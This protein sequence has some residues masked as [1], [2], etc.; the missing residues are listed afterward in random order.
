M[1]DA[2]A[3]PAQELPVSWA[4]ESAV[5]QCVSSAIVLL[6]PLALE[7]RFG[8][9]VVALLL[10]IDAHAIAA[11]MPHHRTCVESDYMACFLNAPADVDIV[12]GDPELRVE[13]AD[14]L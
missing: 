6:G 11:M 10:P 2:T 8:A 1:I 4:V 7:H 14:L 5:P 9:T 3:V 12:T 13:A